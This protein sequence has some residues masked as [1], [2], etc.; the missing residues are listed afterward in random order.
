MKRY[1]IAALIVCTSAAT[2]AEEKKIPK[3]VDNLAVRY[4]EATA[5]FE[6]VAV[7]CPPET[8]VE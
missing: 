2:F 4:A 7:T 8:G 6:L 1:L 3:D 5:Y